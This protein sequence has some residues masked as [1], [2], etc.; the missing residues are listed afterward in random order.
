MFKKKKNSKGLPPNLLVRHRKRLYLHFLHLKVKYRD[1]GEL[2]SIFNIAN[3]GKFL[4]F[5]YNRSTSARVEGRRAAAKFLGKTTFSG[6]TWGFWEVYL[7]KRG[8]WLLSK[9]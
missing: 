5:L 4:A 7:R 8:V 3:I 1:N 9:L 6:G 2:W